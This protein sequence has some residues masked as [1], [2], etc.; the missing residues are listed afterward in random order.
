MMKW[1]TSPIGIALTCQI[2]IP[3]H[4]LEN[5]VLVYKFIYEI[6]ECIS[7]AHSFLIKP[8]Y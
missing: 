3:S 2:D 7:I 8:L 1:T 5:V 6:I 4:Y